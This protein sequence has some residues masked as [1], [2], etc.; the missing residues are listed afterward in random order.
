MNAMLEPRPAPRLTRRPMTPGDLDAVV[1]IE[2]CAYGHPW[3]RGNFS[4][5]LAA[6]YLAEVLV[7]DAGEM[8]GYFIAM[9]GVD[10]LH[11][12]NITVAPRWQRQGHG[13]ALMAALRQHALQLG[14]ATLWL[15]VR[16]SNQRARAL[17]RR[18]GYVE[19]GQRRGY[20]PAAV[21]REDAVVM[22]LAV[23]QATQPCHGLD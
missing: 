2:T 23:H 19:V 18:L 20:Y 17:Y 21:N 12:L 9:T 5:S 8:L 14:M 4:D 10:E 15:E 3:S 1:A 16:Q 11:L 13:Q 22:T 7:D 6:R